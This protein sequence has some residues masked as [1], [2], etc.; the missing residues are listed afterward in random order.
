MAP[1]AMAGCRHERDIFFHRTV[2]VA[3]QCADVLHHVDLLRAGAQSGF[4][5]GNFRFGGGRAERKSDHGADL[6][7]DPASSEAASGTQYG[8]TQTLAKLYWRASPQS[9]K[10][11]SRVASGRSRVWSIRR[12]ILGAEYDISAI[13]SVAFQM[14]AGDLMI[15]QRADC[16]PFGTTLWLNGW[17]GPARDPDGDSE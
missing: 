3:A 6:H 13:K 4:G 12:A 15:T 8:F 11:S 9:F 16:N 10:M 2:V 14:A 1:R 17:H 7:G 5:L